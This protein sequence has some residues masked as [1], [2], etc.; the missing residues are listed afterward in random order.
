MI[1]L[2]WTRGV[3]R[4]RCLALTLLLIATVVGGSAGATVANAQGPDPVSC[5]PNDRRVTVPAD[6]ALDACFDGTNLVILNRTTIPLFVEVEGDLSVSGKTRIAVTSSWASTLFDPIDARLLAPDFKMLIRVGRGQGAVDLR[7]DEDVVRRYGLATLAAGQLPS[8]AGLPEIIAAFLPELDSAYVDLTQCLET[9]TTFFARENCRIGFTWDVGFAISRL[10]VDS[11]LATFEIKQI[12]ALL[13]EWSAAVLDLAL[14]LVSDASDV[15]DITGGLA[16]YEDAGHHLDVPAVCG[17]DLRAPAVSDAIARVP[18]PGYPWDTNPAYRSGNYD[19]CATLSAIRL[20]IRGATGSSPAQIMLFHEGVY[21]GTG[22]REPWSMAEVDVA[23]STDD[24]VVVR[25]GYLR[26]WDDSLAGASGRATVRFTWAGASVRMLDDLPPDMVDP[27]DYGTLVLSLQGFG[28]GAFSWG[29]SQAEAEIALGR[30]FDT[31]YFG[32]DCQQ[33][34]LPPSELAF[35]IRDGL[36]VAAAA[37]ASLGDDGVTTDTGI[38]LG[39]PLSEVRQSYPRIVAEP[40]G[41]DPSNVRYRHTVDG[42]SML[43]T[44][45]GGGDTVDAI[46]VGLAD[47]ATGAVPECVRGD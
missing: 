33:G 38:A 34:S 22:T 39:D 25:Y 12:V 20:L 41:S 37:Y 45:Y 16:D 28:Q 5:R 2:G 18:E 27:P 4:V 1:G 17:V 40:V 13:D 36:V 10:V 30:T 7:A 46:S 11:V 21:V 24:T 8:I 42:R 47:E 31:Q 32:G 19:P 15:N 44:S 35:T 26:P 29:E 43:F 6:F 23:A 14:D 3:A 9:R